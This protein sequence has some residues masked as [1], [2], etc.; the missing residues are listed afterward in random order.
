MQVEWDEKK[1][2][3]NRRKHGV[4]FEEALSVLLDPLA[5]TFETQDR[6]DEVRELTVGH[7][8][9]ERLLLVVHTERRRGTVRLISAREATKRERRQ[10]EEGI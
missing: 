10:Y 3:A 5:V 1:A 2:E 4:G 6:P 9:R 8:Y 7:S